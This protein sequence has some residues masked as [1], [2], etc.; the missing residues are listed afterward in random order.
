M[1]TN[2]TVPKMNT[3]AKIA[4]ELQVVFIFNLFTTSYNKLIMSSHRGNRSL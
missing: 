1:F 4:E 2:Q 3:I